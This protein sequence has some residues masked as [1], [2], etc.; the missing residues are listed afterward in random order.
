M[1]RLISIDTTGLDALEQLHRSRQRRG[2]RLVLC[3]LN[4]QPRSLME[5]SGFA[6]H[7]GAHN[8]VPDLHA[9]VAAAR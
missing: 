3:D 7:L 6:D 4:V 5:R 8:L 1:H 9:A 2:I